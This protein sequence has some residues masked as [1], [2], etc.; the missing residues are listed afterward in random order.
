MRPTFDYILKTFAFDPYDAVK[1]SDLLDIAQM[2]VIPYVDAMTVDRRVFHYFKGA[3]RK[4]K[5]GDRS[6]RYAD[7]V[8]SRVE[9]LIAAMLQ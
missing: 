1:D 8:Y 2:V 6:I 9:D 5:Q 4:L 3:A 7:Y